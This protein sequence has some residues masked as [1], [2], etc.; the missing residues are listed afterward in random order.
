[1][2]L[3][4]LFW[5]YLPL[6]VLV[7]VQVLIIVLFP[8]TAPS[9]SAA[10]SGTSTPPS[11][12]GY[13][14]TAAGRSGDRSHCAG[15]R[16]FST[17]IDYDAPLCTAGTV[18]G[19][20]PNGGS[21][22]QG[23]S[24]RTI[25]VVDYYADPGGAV[26]AIAKAQGL[27]V[28]Y[29]QQQQVNQAFQNF[30]NAHYV[31]WGR[32]LKVERYRSMCQTVPPDYSCLLADMDTVVQTLHPYAVSWL[33]TLCSACF[34]RLAQ[35]HTIAIGGVGFSDAFAR[36]NAP[37]FWSAG[38]SST[39]IEQAFAKFWCNQLTSKGS[40]RVVSF[41][42]DNNS[43]QNFNGQKRVLG[44]IS[45]NDPDNE[46]TVTGVLV[47]ALNR[48]CG[49]G[50]S[51]AAH[52]YFY[53]QDI[54]TAAQ[55][56]DAGITAMNTP[57]HPA[58]DVLCLC[59]PVAP[60]LLFSGQA[61]QNYWPETLLADVQG[62]GTDIAGQ[63]Y[64]SVEFDHA[65]G[66]TSTANLGPAAR[67]AGPRV[68]RLGGGTNLPVQPYV[69]TADWAAWNMLASLIQN[70]GPDL[71]PTRMAA[72]APSMGTIGGGTTGHAEVGFSPGSYDWT[73][74][75]RVAY[76]DQGMAS[77]Y[78]RKPGA[79]VDVEGSRFLPNQYPRLS[80]P[81]IPKVRPS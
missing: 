62:I 3:R 81:P 24:S 34:A 5:R 27:Y 26:D 71:T 9:Q 35:D 23:V 74:D 48:D 4:R 61:K 51:V 60:L 44:V 55:Q 25:T 65:F 59:D 58:T 64:K 19:T 45:T 50:A 52:H 46:D 67:Q 18:G 66:I 29:A 22:S 7:A 57:N 15:T 16:E 49:D 31:L 43:A 2:K 47:P 68:Y 77:S 63:S 33:T 32:R 76:W 73:I 10:G 72:A 28:S 38:E 8:S 13:S 80:E 69:A 6:G 39:H 17:T 1:V 36:A 75:A 11:A 20:Y 30:I 21:T 79:F 78:D 12:V 37:Y 56:I 14:G 70:T 41:A 40:N 53:A 42:P 54:S